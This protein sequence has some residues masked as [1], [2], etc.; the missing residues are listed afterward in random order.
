MWQTQMQTERNEITRLLELVA[1][2]RKPCVRRSSEPDSLLATDLPLVTDTDGVALFRAM[3]HERGWTVTEKNGWLLLDHIPE[4]LTVFSAHGPEALACASLLERHAAV[5]HDAILWREL[6]KACEEGRAAEERAFAKTH[7]LL[8][9]KLRLHA[10]M[11]DL[12]IL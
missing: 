4:K 1:T 10:P 3:A 7:A 6:M 8:A 12:E 5:E 2:G 9:E 11:P